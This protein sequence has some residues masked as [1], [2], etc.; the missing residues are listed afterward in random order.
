VVATQT[1]AIV[2]AGLAGAKAAEALRREG[3]DGRVVLLGEEAV[4]PYERPPLS[5]AY[6][7]GEAG[8][9][10]A[11]VHKEGFYSDHDIDLLT[12]SPVRSLDLRERRLELGDGSSVGYDRLLLAMG[13]SPR[14][15][16]LDGTDFTGVH[17][18]RDIGQADALGQ[19]IRS[20]GRV[21]V[22]GAGWIGCEVAASARE[23]GAEVT[24]IEMASVPLERVLG[25]E[26]G[27]VYRDVH[28]DHGVDLR[29][30]ASVQALRGGEAVEAVELAGGEVVPADVVVIGVG[31]APRTELVTGSAAAGLE[32]DD[33]VVVDK[34]LATSVPGVYA[35]GDV[36]S[37]WHPLYRSRIRLEH[38]S[39]A[40]N[41]GREVAR[42]MLGQDLSYDRIPYF[43]SD[44][45]DVSMEYT[46]WAPRWGRVVFR[47]DVG[48]R[49]FIAFWLDE[50]DRVLAGM[51]V[52]VWEV[53]EAIEAMVR[54]GR[55][56]DVGRLT[57]PEVELAALA[58]DA[59]R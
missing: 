51:N 26:V 38:W 1:F 50:A 52:N 54:S 31:V 2:G 34:S 17:Y 22:I 14:R 6:L 7:R 29:M 24:L 37:A 23:M 49:Q 59:S 25:P 48:G 58:G 53:T 19:A 28:A 8:F 30:G 18:L 42:A 45:Y 16:E 36:A 15:L 46:G 40:L 33:G 20:A 44:Q 10:Q 9:D 4:R 5:K 43:Y 41:Q 39:A 55:P 13:A 12:S 56:V 47:G 27:A 21:A 57:D 32:V 3:F 35:A 11:A